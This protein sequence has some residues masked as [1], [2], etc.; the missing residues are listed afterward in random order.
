[1]PADTHDFTSTASFLI[2]LSH[3]QTTAHRRPRPAIIL[4][5]PLST[6]PDRLW[7]SLTRRPSIDRPG[8]ISSQRRVAI[9][10]RRGPYRFA[11]CGPRIIFMSMH[12]PRLYCCSNPVV[13]VAR[14]TPFHP[15]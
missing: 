1:M 15:L 9:V 6:A 14:S 13:A 7:E 3:A 4:I 5:P 11:I 8:E 2:F 10:R 12:F